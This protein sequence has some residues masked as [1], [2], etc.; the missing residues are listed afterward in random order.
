MPRPVAVQ[1]ADG[2][3]YFAWGA[4]QPSYLFQESVE[5]STLDTRRA[6]NVG[7]VCIVFAG[8]RD[9]LVQEPA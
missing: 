3:T 5:S 1:R 8:V 7:V 2:H 9:P 6:S 4:P